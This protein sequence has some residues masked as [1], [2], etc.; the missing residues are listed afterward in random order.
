MKNNDFASPLEDYVF[1]QIFG[2]QQNIENT[3]AFLT[4]LL[5]V[6]VAEYDRLTVVSPNLESIFKKGKKGILDIRLTT[7]SKKI[8]HIELQVEKRKNMRNRIT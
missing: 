8:I 6:P 5:D 1:K 4:T 7:K 2:E 3:R